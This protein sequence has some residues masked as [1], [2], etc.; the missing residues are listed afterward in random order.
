MLSCCVYKQPTIGLLHYKANST[1]IIIVKTNLP[2][3]TSAPLLPSF[4]RFFRLFFLKSFWNSQRNSQN[5][6]KMK[7]IFKKSS[8]H[9]WS[10]QEMF[11][12]S[13]SSCSRYNANFKF[14][15]SQCS[16][17]MTVRH[18]F[19]ISEDGH[20]RTVSHARDHWWTLDFAN[21]FVSPGANSRGELVPSPRAYGRNGAPRRW[22][23]DYFHWTNNFIKAWYLKNT[24]FGFWTCV[25]CLVLRYS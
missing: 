19:E 24:N 15:Q 10:N 5:L 7:C 12:I 22:L 25:K 20:P 8:N 17:F 11:A 14:D 1:L 4:R 16:L 6:A 23:G 9:L 21:A 2:S 18:I 13:L 3:L